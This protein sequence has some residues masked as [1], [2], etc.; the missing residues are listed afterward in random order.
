VI[1]GDTATMTGLATID[2][3]TFGMGATYADESS[4]GFNANVT[5]NLTATKR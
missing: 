3:R 1:T 5:V 2:R 4:V